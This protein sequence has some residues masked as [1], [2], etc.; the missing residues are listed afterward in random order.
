MQQKGLAVSTVAESEK[1]L[2]R[3]DLFAAVEIGAFRRGRD[4]LWHRVRRRVVAE[5]MGGELTIKGRHMLGPGGIPFP[6]EIGFRLALGGPPAPIP[7]PRLAVGRVGPGQ[8]M[9]EVVEGQRRVFFKAQGDIAEQKF[10]VGI[11]LAG[12]HPMLPGD[13]IGKIGVAAGEQ[14]PGNDLAL[15]PPIR[16]L[17][18]V[19]RVGLENCDRLVGHVAFAPPAHL[20]VEEPGIG[21][22]LC[23]DAG[24]ERLGG[25]DLKGER[26]TRLGQCPEIG[27]HP[28]QHAP[29]RLGSFVP[30]Q[31]VEPP[32]VI[33]GADRDRMLGEKALFVHRVEIA[34]D[35]GRAQCRRATGDIT[36][37]Q[38]NLGGADP[39]RG[40]ERRIVLQPIGGDRIG[41]TGQGLFGV[42]AQRLLVRPI[43]VLFDEIGDIGKSAGG[44]R[45][46][47]I[48]PAQHLERKR[49]LDRCCFGVGPVPIAGLGRGQ[50]RAHCP[51][52]GVGKHL[53]PRRRDQRNRHGTRQKQAI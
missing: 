5:L 36:R 41:F 26:Q 19:A 39:A 2:R 46:G 4:R 22:Q 40:A 16:R 1:D 13:A 33:L 29:H 9:R 20:L 7:G 17:H 47:V 15:V 43:R 52:I 21:P 51:E 27:R 34:V 12:E 50:R 30:E 6:G 3:A 10:C 8:N 32:F 23:R 25:R 49:V 18:R 45:A 31:P 14:P 53:R 42:F 48:H 44:A 35:P 24:G 37:I 28:H 11:G 38:Q